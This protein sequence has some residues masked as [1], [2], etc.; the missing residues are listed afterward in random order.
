MV[1][2]EWL[3]SSRHDIRQKY[4]QNID[5]VLRNIENGGHQ[6]KNIMIAVKQE[7]QI[8]FFFSSL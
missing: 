5:N 2:K 8:F 3:F 6:H 1:P 7:S 4:C